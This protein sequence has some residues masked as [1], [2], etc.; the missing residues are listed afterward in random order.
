MI[1]SLVVDTGDMHAYS[2]SKLYTIIRGMKRNHSFYAL[3][4]HQLMLA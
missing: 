1:A 3:K 2:D 4:L